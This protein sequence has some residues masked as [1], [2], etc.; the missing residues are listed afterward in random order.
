M[1]L[2]AAHRLLAV[3]PK[4]PRLTAA[5]SAVRRL[6]ESMTIKNGENYSD[7]NF[8]NFD[9]FL[10][11]KA[12]R[13]YNPVSL[14]KKDGLQ[15][16]YVKARGTGTHKFILVDG[17]RPAGDQIIGFLDVNRGHV[18][19]VSYISP[20]YRGR[21]LGTV[22]YLSGIHTLGS[23]LSSWSIGI[24]AVRTWGSVSKYHAVELLKIT[25]PR[26]KIPV[27]YKWGSSGI[28]V[29]DGRPI[30]KIRADFQFRATK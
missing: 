19:I 8:Q 22:L 24:M 18:V 5:D 2:Q 28:P 26:S 12:L 25:A 16:F 14:G 9:R 17:S 30:N 20:S 23:L 4:T 11:R 27:S 13:D 6:V 3:S 15:L 29:V 1:K 21:G 10:L 7:R